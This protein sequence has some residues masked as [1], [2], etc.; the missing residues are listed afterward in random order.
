PLDDG[1]LPKKVYQRPG[2]KATLRPS[3]LSSQPSYPLPRGSPEGC[4]PV[5]TWEVG[6]MHRGRV[7]ETRFGFLV[8][9]VAS[10]IFSFDS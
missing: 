5:N 6:P 2:A 1:G 9:D 7:G 4:G 8:L 10:T 3:H